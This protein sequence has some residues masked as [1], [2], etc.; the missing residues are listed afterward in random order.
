MSSQP[1][2]ALLRPP[3]EFSS[4]VTNSAMG[5]IAMCAPQILMMPGGV[6]YAVGSVFLVRAALLAA[7]CL[8]LKTY[9]RG[10]HVLP[11]YEINPGDI[12]KD[13]LELFLGKGF[14]WGAKHTQRRADLDRPEYAHYHRMGA[15][16]LGARRIID[17]LGKVLGRW[18]AA[19]FK[20]QSL[21]NP[22]PPRPYVEGNPALHAVGLFEKEQH[23]TVRQ[24]ERVAHTFVVGTT[25]VGKWICWS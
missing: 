14:E 17:C 15:L 18:A 2:E 21:L 7:H 16:H 13:P 22:F 25:R 23:I 20:S 3:V 24:S 8:K 12:K 4:V 5:I 11:P 1:I 19:P 6:G 9:Q 10:L